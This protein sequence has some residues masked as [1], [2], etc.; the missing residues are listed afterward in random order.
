[1]SWHGICVAIAEAISRRAASELERQGLKP[2]E[3]GSAGSAD[4]SLGTAPDL[5]PDAPAGRA[6]SEPD[7]ADV[8]V[9]RGVPVDRVLACPRRLTFTAHDGSYS[10]GSPAGSQAS[11]QDRNMALTWTFGAPGR[12]RT[13]DPLLRR[14]P[15]CP[16]ELQAHGS[17]LCR[18]K[19]TRRPRYGVGPVT[20][21]GPATEVGFA[22]HVGRAPPG[23]RPAESDL[24]LASRRQETD[25]VLVTI[26]TTQDPA[27]DLEFPTAQAPGEGAE[28]PGDRGDGARLLSR[29]LGCSGIAATGAS[30][31]APTSATGRPAWP[32]NSVM[33]LD[34]RLQSAC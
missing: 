19:V 27:A 18:A 25:G 29:S 22:R 2:S 20:V 3:R 15:L 8:L 12:I 26:S 1:M 10:T 14:Q 6:E 24:L 33:P 30:G 11:V 16:S 5:P 9:L 32:R 31:L 23:R 34:P 4:L 7:R 13:R 21:T 17:P 28:L